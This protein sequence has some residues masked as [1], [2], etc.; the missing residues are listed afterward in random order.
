[1]M[2][3]TSPD[4]P[5]CES[6]GLVITGGSAG[7]RS[8]FDELLALHFSNAVYF[9]V[10][11]LFVDTYC[12]QHPARGCASFKSLAAHLAHLCW[13]LE[14][15]GT[16][17]IPCEQIRRWVE[18]NPQAD[19]P[20]PPVFRGSLTIAH[21]ACTGTPA[22]HHRAVDEWA[23]ATWEA[24]EPLHSTAREWVDRAFAHDLKR[25]HDGRVL[26]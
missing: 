11:R 8:I 22:D 10:H 26:R 14:R 7:C 3:S 21:V 1:M 6:C 20:D 12:L 24:Y 19:R 17:A 23:R 5:E 15:G 13:S 9:G 18:R 4:A 16:R 2:M 25:Q